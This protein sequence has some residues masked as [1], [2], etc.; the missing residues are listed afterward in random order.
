MIG[1]CWHDANVSWERGCGK[2]G[3]GVNGS[4]LRSRRTGFQ[5]VYCGRM[6]QP[7]PMS[8]LKLAPFGQHRLSPAGNPATVGR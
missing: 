5:P 3:F 6:P 2:P 4:S 1:I 8:V 7:R